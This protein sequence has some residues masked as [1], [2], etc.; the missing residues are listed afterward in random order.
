LAGGEVDDLADVLGADLGD[1]RRGLVGSS[2]ERARMKW[3]LRPAISPRHMPS[4][5]RCSLVSERDSNRLKPGRN[6]TSSA[7]APLWSDLTVEW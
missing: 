2:V 5:G 1:G 7:F 4:S 6:L 3:R